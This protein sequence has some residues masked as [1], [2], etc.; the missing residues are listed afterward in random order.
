MRRNAQTVIIKGNKQF[1]YE[2]NTNKTNKRIM[3]ISLEHLM[4]LNPK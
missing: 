1:T 2:T 3:G 4:I